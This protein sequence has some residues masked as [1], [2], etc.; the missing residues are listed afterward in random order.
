MTDFLASFKSAL[1]ERMGPVEA[2]VG[3][4]ATMKARIDALGA[5]ETAKVKAAV[6]IVG[7]WWDSLMTAIGPRRDAQVEGCM[8]P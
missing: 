6:D 5:T 8:G 1:D 7:V 4:I 2:A 3:E